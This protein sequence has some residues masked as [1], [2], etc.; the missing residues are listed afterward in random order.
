MR[1]KNYTNLSNDRIRDIIGFVKPNGLFTSNFDV[2]ITNSNHIYC[3]KFYRYGGYSRN[4]SAIGARG[5]PLIIARITKNENEY[6]HFTEYKPTKVVKLYYDNF[7]ERKRRWEEGWCCSIHV[8]KCTVIKYSSSRGAVWL[9]KDHWNS[10]RIIRPKNGNT[11][12]YIDYLILSREEALVYVLAHEF[13]HFWQTNHQGKR[14]KIWGAR[15]V[16]SDRDAD[17]YAIKKT[18]AWRVIHS[19][20]DA[21]QI[22]RVN[23]QLIENDSFTA[24]TSL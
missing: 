16:Y 23:L 4:N 12:G 22:G 10:W 3:G 1:V 20:N 9:E 17:A 8:A 19:P 13:R 24:A 2:K 5:R 15:G 11:G 21:I 6:P 7:D 14:G 18:R